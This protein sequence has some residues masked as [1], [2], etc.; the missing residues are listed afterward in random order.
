MRVEYRAKLAWAMLRR[1]SFYVK[2]YFIYFCL[3]FSIF[4][5]YAPQGHK[6][7]QVIFLRLL[8]ILHPTFY[9][10]HF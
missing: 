6:T 10:I 2:K 5:F 8:N 9:I 7:Y 4:S 3:F 1:S